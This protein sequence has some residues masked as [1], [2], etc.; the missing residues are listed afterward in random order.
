MHAVSVRSVRGPMPASWKPCSSSRAISNAFQPPSGPIARRIRSRP[1]PPT[2]SP[3]SLVAVGLATVETLLGD[4]DLATE[5]AD[6]DA[7]RGL[8]QHG[9]DLLDR[10]TLLHGTP[11]GP[12]RTDVPQT[13]PANGLKKR[14]PHGRVSPIMATLRDD[15]HSG[16]TK[17][18]VVRPSRLG[19]AD[20]GPCT[21]PNGRGAQ[22]ATMHAY[23]WLRCAS[24]CYILQHDLVADS[25]N[26]PPLHATT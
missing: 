20:Y 10:E 24:R 17:R 19:Q 3:S 22:A 4:P 15:R 2:T 26:I 18:R 14:A 16:T 12:R 5:I 13:H 6:G 1:L 23:G 8:L 11:P 7:L 21:E 25:D 9:G